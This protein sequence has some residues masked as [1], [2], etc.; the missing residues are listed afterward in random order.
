M[1]EDG[2]KYLGEPDVKKMGKD[3]AA[4]K[5]AMCICE[6]STKWW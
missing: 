6:S 3:L 1:V 5:G 2:I 4:S